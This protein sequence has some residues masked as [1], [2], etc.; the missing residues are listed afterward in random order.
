MFDLRPL[1]WLGEISYSL[2]LYHFIL[3]VWLAPPADA[4]VFVRL[5]GWGQLAAPL[6]RLDGDRGGRDPGGLAVLRAGGTPRDR[7]RPSSDA[8]PA[9]RRRAARCA[10]RSGLKDEP[11]AVPRAKKTLTT[12]FTDRTDWIFWTEN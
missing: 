12:D 6:R 9:C 3:F 11:A 10:A 5:D 1:L 2:Y 8:A 7:R 4:A